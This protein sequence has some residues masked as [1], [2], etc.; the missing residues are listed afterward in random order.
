MF[1]CRE[2]GLHVQAG[3]TTSHIPTANL[4][5]VFISQVSLTQ[6]WVFW[7]TLKIHYIL[8]ACQGQCRIHAM[9]NVSVVLP[10]PFISYTE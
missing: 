4:I 10:L 1:Y 6:V 7:L 2:K 5:L 9:A 3:I 8:G